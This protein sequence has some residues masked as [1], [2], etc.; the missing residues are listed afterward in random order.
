M[1]TIINHNFF[2]AGTD[3]ISVHQMMS[4]IFGSNAF[5]SEATLKKKCNHILLSIQ[6]SPT[7]GKVSQLEN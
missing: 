4:M 3:R 6:L 2:L 7:H 1:Y 5:S